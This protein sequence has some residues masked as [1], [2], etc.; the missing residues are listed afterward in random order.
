MCVTASNSCGTSSPSC[1]VVTVESPIGAIALWSGTLSSIPQG[2]VL[3]DGN[4]GTPDLRDKF[5][6]S[7]ASAE[8]PGATGGALTHDHGGST[9][10]YS[11]SSGPPSS[12]I[13]AAG[14]SPTF[15]TSSTH[16]HGSTHS[17][18][19]SS[20]SNAPPYYEVAFIMRQ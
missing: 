16:T 5:I 9:G 13:V 20:M 14:G 15:V 18:P 1:A 11:F 17:H 19:I 6:K 3:C 7:V 10:S 12:T 4:N 8:N 2:W